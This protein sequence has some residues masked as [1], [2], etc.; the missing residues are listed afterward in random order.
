MTKIFPQFNFSRRSNTSD[1]ALPQRGSTVRFAKLG[2]DLAVIS[3]EQ[4]SK[5]EYKIVK[6]TMCET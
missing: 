5:I 1:E 2:D 4:A 6:L 3:R